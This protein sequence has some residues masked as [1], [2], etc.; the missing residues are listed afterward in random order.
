MATGLRA[1]AEDPGSISRTH[2]ATQPFL[3]LR[4]SKILIL[5]SSSTRHEVCT[6][7][8]TGKTPTHKK[9]IPKV[10]K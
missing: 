5:A 4:S 1:F 9:Y 10:K 2:M 6:H 8:Y 3:S 7:I